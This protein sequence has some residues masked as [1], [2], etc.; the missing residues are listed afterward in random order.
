MQL[1]LTE[2]V[3]NGD[4]KMGGFDA[5]PSCFYWQREQQSQLGNMGK[6]ISHTVNNTGLRSAQWN[7][8]CYT[9]YSFLMFQVA[10]YFRITKS[11]DQCLFPDII[12]KYFFSKQMQY[13]FLSS[14]EQK[15]GVF[16]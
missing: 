7:I 15:P 10:S 8:L 6:A 5:N 2:A 9:E 3:S 14:T 12:F 11:S 4:K 1:H 13:I 16:S